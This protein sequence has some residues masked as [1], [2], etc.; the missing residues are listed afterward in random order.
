ME[1]S[2]PGPLVLPAALTYLIARA[3]DTVRVRRGAGLS[4]ARL[5]GL[6]RDAVRHL[7][8]SGAT[9]AEVHAAVRD[10]CEAASAGHADPDLHDALG[11]LEARARAFATTAAAS[12]APRGAEPGRPPA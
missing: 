3:V 1:P 9:V 12:P 6:L 5:D 11:E 7:A 4:T 2:T 10:V 8:E